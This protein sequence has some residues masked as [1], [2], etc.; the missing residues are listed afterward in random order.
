MKGNLVDE[1]LVGTS[2][3][4]DYDGIGQLNEAT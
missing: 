4:N 3:G 2:D 1:V